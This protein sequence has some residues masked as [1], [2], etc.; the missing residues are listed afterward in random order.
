MKLTCD[1]SANP[2]NKKQD[3]IHLAIL[4]VIALGIGVYLIAATVVI[5]KDGV[6]YIEQ[7]KVSPLDFRC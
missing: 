5:T 1:K 3:L 2:L 7:S 6:W 4:L